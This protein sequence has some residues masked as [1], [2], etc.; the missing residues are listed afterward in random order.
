MKNYGK[1]I[2]E[3]I[4]FWISPGDARSCDLKLYI[5]AEAW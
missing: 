2:R 5:P 4:G 1:Y 3:T